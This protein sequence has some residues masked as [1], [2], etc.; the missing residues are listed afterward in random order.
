MENNKY[1]LIYEHKHGTD[2][3]YFKSN[4]SLKEV[5][6]N[7]SH[8]INIFKA[9]PISIFDNY[10]IKEFKEPTFTIVYL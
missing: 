4:L 1:E 9:N 10:Y 5:I 6:D 8:I 3:Y 7:Q 2:I